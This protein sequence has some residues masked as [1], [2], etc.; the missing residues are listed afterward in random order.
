MNFIKLII[1]EIIKIFKK[2][3]TIIFLVLAILSFALSYSLTI[4]SK[5]SI[6]SYNIISNTTEDI[7]K[8]VTKLKTK[9]K[10]TSKENKDMINLKIE[11]LEY[12][13]SNNFSIS[14]GDGYYKADL[15]QTILK[16]IKNLTP[17]EYKTQIDNI[18]KLKNIIYSNDFES[19]INYNKQNL[20]NDFNNNLISKETY[21]INIENEN[22][23]LKYEIGKY[24]NSSHISFWKVKLLQENKYFD[25]SIENGYDTKDLT[26][27]TNN[28]LEKL[29]V[30]KLL[31]IID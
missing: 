28:E 20:K 11:L 21:E 14:S 24:P 13:I 10:T 2:K 23:N 8:A 29:K 16:E 27:L 6:N 15:I 7:Q 31:I 9:L 12:A 22:S 18:S 1:N 26:P 3:L 5:N 19:Y 30:K 25:T 4:L 17:V